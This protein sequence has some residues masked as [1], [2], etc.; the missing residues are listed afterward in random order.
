MQ[1]TI[2]TIAAECFTLWCHLHHSACSKSQ[3]FTSSESKANVEVNQNWIEYKDIITFVDFKIEKKKN[4]CSAIILKIRFIYIMLLALKTTCPRRFGLP[5]IQQSNAAS[6]CCL[7]A[8]AHWSLLA[9]SQ[10]EIV[11]VGFRVLGQ[12]RPGCI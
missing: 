2:I 7:L 6:T 9:E 10:L 3:H 5:S 11:M 8:M 1:V 4:K 12:Q